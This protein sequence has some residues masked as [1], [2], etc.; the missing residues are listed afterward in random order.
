MQLRLGGVPMPEA[1]R[2]VYGLRHAT[3]LELLEIS[4]L[5]YGSEKLFANLHQLPDALSRLIMDLRSD[6]KYKAQKLEYIQYVCTQR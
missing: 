6:A 2:L 5:S 3:K 1:M 4:L